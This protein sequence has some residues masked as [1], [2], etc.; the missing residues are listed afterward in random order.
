MTV[1]SPDQ[2]RS[3]RRITK[4]LIIFLLSFAALAGYAA[5]GISGNAARLAVQG[6]AAPATVVH[7]QERWNNRHYFTGTGRSGQ[8]LTVMYRF[9][10]DGRTMQGTHSVDRERFDALQ[11]GQTVKVL[12]L[13]ADPTVS[14]IDVG[15]IGQNG[16]WA[17]AVSLVFALLAGLL[18]MVLRRMPKAP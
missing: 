7:K 14:E 16:L 1:A 3:H 4:A 2:I 9:V 17:G 8:Y 11:V 12:Y 6:V 5:V 10:A 18:I 13:P 15:W